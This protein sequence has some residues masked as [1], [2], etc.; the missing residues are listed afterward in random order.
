[1]K[2]GFLMGQDKNKQIAIFRRDYQ[3]QGKTTPFTGAIATGRCKTPGSGT[4]NNGAD[5]DLSITSPAC[6]K[7]LWCWS[8]NVCFACTMKM[9]L[10][11]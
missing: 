3:R 5:H 2:G 1:M 11:G 10:T 7:P 4:A 6:L 8:A 9:P